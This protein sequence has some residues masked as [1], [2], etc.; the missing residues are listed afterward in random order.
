MFGL[1]GRFKGGISQVRRGVAPFHNLVPK[2]DAI[3]SGII[4]S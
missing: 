2:F 4:K 3:R 1:L